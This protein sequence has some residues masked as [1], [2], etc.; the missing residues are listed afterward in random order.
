MG[1]QQQGRIDDAWDLHAAGQ[2]KRCFYEITET[3]KPDLELS[4]MNN[5]W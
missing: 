4:Q 3:A 5:L 2:D 1:R